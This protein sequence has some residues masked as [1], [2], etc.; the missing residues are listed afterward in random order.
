MITPLHCMHVI[1]IW[2][3][4]ADARL[5]LG[6]FCSS[7]RERE[8]RALLIFRSPGLIHELVVGAS[9]M[10]NVYKVGISYRISALKSCFFNP[11]KKKYD[12]IASLLQYLHIFFCFYFQIE[13]PS[14]PKKSA[15]HLVL[16]YHEVLVGAVQQCKWVDF[17]QL[18]ATVYYWA[19]ASVGLLTTLVYYEQSGFD[20]A[21][22]AILYDEVCRMSWLI[23]DFEVLLIS[24]HYTQWAKKEKKCNQ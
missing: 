23:E 20:V 3:E 18:G 11:A 16:W 13:I 5:K 17:A 1:I 9:A 2:P 6:V 24:K 14:L 22:W 10:E 8:L 4:K 12:F 7:F 19:G 21:Q 15:H